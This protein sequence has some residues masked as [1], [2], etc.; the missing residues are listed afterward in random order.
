MSL[1]SDD[2]YERYIEYKKRMQQTPNSNFE[3]ESDSDYIKNEELLKMDK[4]YILSE[5]NGITREKYH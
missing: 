5:S 2:S 3:F 4:Y 1:I